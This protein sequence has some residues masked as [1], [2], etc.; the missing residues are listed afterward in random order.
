MNA[1]SCPLGTA[2]ILTNS[3]TSIW[4]FKLHLHWINVLEFPCI[5]QNH[6]GLLRV[7]FRFKSSSSSSVYLCPQKQPHFV[8]HI[9]AA[10]LLLLISFTFFYINILFEKKKGVVFFRCW[11]RPGKSL[12]LLQ[13]KK[14]LCQMLPL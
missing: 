8:Y 14:A 7:S 9:W 2:R 4:K 12:L 1:H 6:L 5:I 10:Y 11:A 13:G 3:L